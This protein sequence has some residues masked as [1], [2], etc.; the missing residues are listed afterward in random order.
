ML[1]RG[2]TLKL[3]FLIK[4]L[5]QGMAYKWSLRD[6]LGLICLKLDP[7]YMNWCYIHVHVAT[8]TRKTQDSKLTF[9]FSLID[10]NHQLIMIGIFNNY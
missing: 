10:S 3:V 9:R 1:K 6:C 7:S 5:Y 2:V 4:S 8:R